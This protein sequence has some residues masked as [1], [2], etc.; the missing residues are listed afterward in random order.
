MSLFGRRQSVGRWQHGAALAVLL[1]AILAMAAQPL[2][3]VPASC[4]MQGER[5]AMSC[6]GCCAVKACCASSEREESSPLAA[7][8]KSPGDLLPAI[9]WQSVAV[10]LPLVQHIQY[11]K[12]ARLF[13][14]AHAPSPLALNCIQLI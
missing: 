13:A 7:V 3:A 8:V 5:Q 14:D 9:T 1:L 12:I 4:Q 6:A 10:P 11:P 2:L